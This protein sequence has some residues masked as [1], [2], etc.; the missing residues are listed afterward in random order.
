MKSKQ[1]SVVIPRSGKE[2]EGIRE[3]C[4]I[5]RVV[6]DAA[7]AAIRPGITTDAIDE[8]VHNVTIEHGAYP[9]PY[10]YFNYPKSVCTSI[11]EIICHGIPDR[12]P[13]QDGD[14]V[15]VDVSVYYKGWHGDLNET[16][17][18]G[19]NVDE[20]SKKLVKVTYEC[21]H[22]AIAA[23]RP[24][25]RYRD[26][27]DIISKHANKAGFSVVKTYCGHGIG[28][29]FHCAPNVPHYAHN[30]AKG[31]MK[32]GDV[33]TI[34]PMINVGS[35]RDKLWP[36]G[37]TSATEDGK[38]SAQFEHQLVITEDG[39]EILTARLPTSPPLWWEKEG[40]DV[41]NGGDEKET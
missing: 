7:H 9:S 41:A 17:I 18:V 2:L 20:E 6:L 36:D 24:G 28:N 30:K 5:G 13:L 15:N 40:V 16:F 1:Q 33:F 12:R 8:I 39:C 10:N 35:H 14:I 3:A 26:L 23:C 34:E 19:D 37:W 21:L 38:R 25:T 27:G 11:N 4:R 29:H 22:L 32:V 31:I